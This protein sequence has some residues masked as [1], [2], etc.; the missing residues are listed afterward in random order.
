MNSSQKGDLGHPR[1]F[2]QSGNDLRHVLGDIHRSR[3]SFV[4]VTHENQ[5]SPI[6]CNLATVTASLH[7]PNSAINNMM[8]TGKFHEPKR[9]TA[10]A[11][12]RIM[13]AFS[14]TKAATLTL[15]LAT[16]VSKT[17]QC[18]ALSMTKR[19]S[20]RQTPHNLDIISR[21]ASTN[22]V[23]P[24]ACHHALI[25]HL[26][27]FGSPFKITKIRGG[28]ASSS[29]LFSTSSS[30]SNSDNHGAVTP[31]ETRNLKHLGQLALS[32]LMAFAYMRYQ[33]MVI[34]GSVAYFLIHRVG[35]QGRKTGMKP[36]LRDTILVGGIFA[37]LQ[38]TQ[39]LLGPVRLVVELL[40]TAFFS[41]MFL[42]I[43][44]KQQTA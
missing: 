17:Y 29:T 23:A 10:N 11:S 4:I 44:S 33:Q 28:A 30:G 22:D 13:T 7:N 12:K 8:V 25:Q 18:S 21:V 31:N 27:P 40:V 20:L 42:I 14:F 34:L 2:P 37:A 5:A 3:S 15:I 43:A 1:L 26:A 6:F 39:R 36:V 38:I 16:I 41:Y 32:G 24:S 9:A 19:A 35:M